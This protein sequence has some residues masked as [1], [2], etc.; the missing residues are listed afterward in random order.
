MVRRPVR[1]FVH[2]HV[3]SDY[4]LL[5]GAAKIDDLVRGRGAVRAAG[6]RPDRP[7]QPLRRDRVLQGVPEAGRQAD[8]RH[9]GVPRAALAA[10]PAAQPRRRPPPHAARAERDGLPQPD[11]ALHP[12]LHGGLLLRPAH[13]QGAPERAERGADRPVGLPVRRALLLRAPRRPR[14]RDP[15]GRRDA[16][17]LRRP[18][19]PRAAAQ[20]LRRAGG[21]EPGAAA[22]RPA[23]T[24]SRSSPP[25]TSTTSRRATRRPT[26]CTCASAWARRSRTAT[27]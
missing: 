12:L 7:R 17:H 10:G 13:R 16:R 9:R 11:Q 19:L 18:L 4:S 22:D 21:G 3:H 27:G 6:P 23:R 1:S 15:G 25:T 26:R 5:D 24:G 2:T 20:R 14:A 8:R